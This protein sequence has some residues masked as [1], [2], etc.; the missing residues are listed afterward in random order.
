MS[1]A[2]KVSFGYAADPRLMEDPEPITRLF[3]EEMNTLARAA[4]DKEKLAAPAAPRSESH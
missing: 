4:D 2:E 3:A 1:Y